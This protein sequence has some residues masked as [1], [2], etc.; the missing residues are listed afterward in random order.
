[1]IVNLKLWCHVR[2]N[3]NGQASMRP[4]AS[5]AYN[6]KITNLKTIH[7]FSLFYRDCNHISSSI[8]ENPGTVFMI[9]TV[10]WSLIDLCLEG[11][12]FGNK[13]SVLC[14]LTLLKKNNHSRSR[15]LFRNF[16]HVFAMLI[17][18]DKHY[19]L[20]SLCSLLSIYGYRCLWCTSLHT[21]SKWQFYQ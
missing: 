6:H 21:S 16:R 18:E 2:I 19:F 11:L 9:S 1:M 4:R 7:L 17:E 8:P 10:E 12:F 3:L 15:N 20:S 5:D 13:I 14:A